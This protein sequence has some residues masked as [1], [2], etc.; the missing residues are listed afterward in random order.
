[1]SITLFHL[2][3]AKIQQL[4]CEAKSLDDLTRSLPQGFYTTFTT[5]GGGKF[6]L[7]LSAHLKRLYAPAAAAGIKPVAEAELRSAIAAL[8]KINLPYESRVRLILTKK[9]AKMYI[10]LQPF[11]PLPEEIYRNGVRVITVSASRHDPRIKDTAF[12]TES[13]SQRALLGKD[14][15]EA[16][17][18]KNGHIL[19]GMTSNFYAVFSPQEVLM[20]AQK[21]ILLGVTRRVVIRLARESGLRV[22]FR[23]PMLQSNFDEAF[24]TSSSRGVVPITYINDKRVGNGKA[25]KYTKLL[26]RQYLAYAQKHSEP[27]LR[28]AP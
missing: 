20:T 5:R 9:T 1:M 7:G 3:A 2:T 10:A 26:M 13:A 23:A 19:E 11:V 21:G 27:I 16:L 4:P 24:L 18:E 17:L 25:G 28:G 8:V 12:I 22:V 14:V 6:A 15:F